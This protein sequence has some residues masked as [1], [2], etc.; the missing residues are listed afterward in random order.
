[1]KNL[2]QGAVPNL[3]DIVMR[4]K[5]FVDRPPKVFADRLAPTPV[6]NTEIAFGILNAP[7][8]ARASHFQQD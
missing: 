4:G 3:H 8:T 1:M 7:I 6:G 2:E 5:A